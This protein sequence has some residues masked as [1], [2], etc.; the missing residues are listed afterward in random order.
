MEK[1]VKR[2]VGILLVL[3]IASSATAGPVWEV[4]YLRCHPFDEQG[5]K[6]GDDEECP[7]FKATIIQLISRPELFDGK[8]VILQGFVHQEF[9]GRGLFINRQDYKDRLRKL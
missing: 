7:R 3:L 6:I 1:L 4:P 5:R 9:E 2:L 8:R